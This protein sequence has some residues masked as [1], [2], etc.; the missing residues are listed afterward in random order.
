MFL[1]MRGFDQVS[2]KT[3]TA[4]ISK[5]RKPEMDSVNKFLVSFYMLRIIVEHMLIKI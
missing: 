4:I 3:C 2:T 5:V 1:M